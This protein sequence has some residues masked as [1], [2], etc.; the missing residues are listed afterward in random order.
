MLCQMGRCLKYARQ[1]RRRLIIDTNVHNFFA[2]NWEH[3]FF[4][5]KHT[6]CTLTLRQDQFTQLHRL[7]CHPAALAD[8][9][10]TYQAEQIPPGHKEET[11]RHLGHFINQRDASSK[12]P[13]SFDFRRDH[14]E[15][16]LV[17]HCSGNQGV[18]DAMA[19]LQGLWPQPW[20][21]RCLRLRIHTL[22]KSYEAL[23]LRHTDLK[24]DL[25]AALRQANIP[26]TMPMVI[27]SDSHQAIEAARLA[28]IHRPLYVASQPINPLQHGLAA[29]ATT[30]R[31]A[32]VIPRRAINLAAVTDLIVL[33]LAT[34][35]GGA[36]LLPGQC[37]TRSGYLELALALQ[38]RADLLQRFTC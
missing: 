16:L 2:E 13:L 20:L 27:A 9:L 17:H 12:M 36:E 37:K 24:S 22:P 5:S 14:P 33:A 38:A 31:N 25:H 32:T 18:E 6:P 7:S 34:K 28:V 15:D 21:R 30:H 26:T 35:L 3:Y 4:A 23:H 1:Y 10:D 29:D 11:S 19:A 8:R